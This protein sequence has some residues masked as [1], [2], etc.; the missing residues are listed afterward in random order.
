[1][2]SAAPNT[3]QARRATTQETPDE[4]RSLTLRERPAVQVRALLEQHAL[5]GRHVASQLCKCSA[6]ALLRLLEP[7]V[8][9]IELKVFTQTQQRLGM[10]QCRQVVHGVFGDFKED[11]RGTVE[12]IIDGAI[13]GLSVLTVRE[14]D[15]AS[16]FCL[17]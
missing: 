15:R 14:A 8:D 12:E 16:E 6:A 5:Q 9:G 3:S 4:Q 2:L 10:P 13:E 11:L 17:R 1:M 7:K